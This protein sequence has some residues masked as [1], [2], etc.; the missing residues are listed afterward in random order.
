VKN[1][2]YETLHLSSKRSDPL[3]K[4]GKCFVASL[5]VGGASIL[6]VF[7]RGASAN[8]L[9]K[10]VDLREA[11]VSVLVF[12]GKPGSADFPKVTLPECAS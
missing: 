8:D 11:P 7:C 10:F 6:V 5:F 2:S 4:L 3:K 9:L 12:F 1:S